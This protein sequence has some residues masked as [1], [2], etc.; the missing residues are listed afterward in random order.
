MACCGG[1]VDE[2]EGPPGPPAGAVGV[3]TQYRR[4][5]ST[6]APVAQICFPWT[7]AQYDGRGEPFQMLLAP[8]VTMS[9][10]WGQAPA[11]F[12]PETCGDAA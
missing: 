3:F 7:R 6:G 12:T 10:L 5:G 9:V 1:A 11:V 2:T 8:N 4:A